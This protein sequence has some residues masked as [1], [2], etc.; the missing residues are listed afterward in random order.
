MQIGSYSFT[1]ICQLSA[2]PDDIGEARAFQP[3]TAYANR[4]CL[5]IHSYG[6]G[7]FCKFKIDSHYR[8]SGVYALTIEDELKYLGEC[9]DLSSRYNSGYGQISPRNCFVGG[10]RTNCRINNLIYKELLAGKRVNLWFM[11][12]VE[13]KA[14]EKE[15]LSTLR[16]PWNLR[17]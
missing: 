2:E 13:R 15:L 8:A 12:T 9:Q 4:A 3:Q 10:Q 7:P 14:I 5:E 1:H 6:D 17:H 11:K 16:P